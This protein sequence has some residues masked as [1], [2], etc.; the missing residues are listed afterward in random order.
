[1]DLLDA[2]VVDVIEVDD[3]EVDVAVEDGFVVVDVFVVRPSMTESLTS[4]DERFDVSDAIARVDE[5]S[6]SLVAE[7][8]LAI[9]V[10]VEERSFIVEESSVLMESTFVLT[11]ASL[12]M[13]ELSCETV[14]LRS[15][16]I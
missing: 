2:D 11:E 4:A 9:C 16:W 15:S 7:T 13:V 8:S 12:E 14:E 6:A 5:E 1:M 10:L 3:T